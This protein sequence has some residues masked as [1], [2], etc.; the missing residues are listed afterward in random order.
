MN[1]IIKITLILAIASVTGCYYDTEERLYPTLYNP[2]D[3]KD[4]TF[5]K[6]VSTIL[7][8]CLSCHSNSM[9]ASDGGGVKLENYNDIL[10]YV[11]NQQLMQAVNHQ[12]G[13]AMPKGEGKLPQCEIDQLQKWIDNQTPNN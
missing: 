4:V 1:R 7:Q 5:S 2:C 6:T 8:P 12:N 11:N 10:I 3:D 13:Y 9:S